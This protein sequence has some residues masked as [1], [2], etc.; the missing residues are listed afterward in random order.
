MLGLGWVMERFPAPMRERIAESVCD[1]C[2]V[3]KSD[4]FRL[5]GR[6]DHG[7]RGVLHV[8]AHVGQEAAAYNFSGV[9]FVLWVEPI[10]ASCRD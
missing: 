4:L 1:F 3:P 6:R 7:R 9:P 5:L 10:P 2:R 8:G